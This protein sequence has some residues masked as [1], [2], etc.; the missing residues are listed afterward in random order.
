MT[1]LAIPFLIHDWTDGAMDR[2]LLPIDA[3]S[4]KLSIKVGKSSS[5]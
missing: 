5:L 4:R 3:E 2:K 1:F